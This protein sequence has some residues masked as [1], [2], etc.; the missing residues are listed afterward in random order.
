MKRVVARES[1]IVGTYDDETLLALLNGGTL[2]LTDQY[3]NAAQ[4]IWRPL[5]DFIGYSAPVRRLA[6]ALLRICAL[7]VAAGCGSLATWFYLNRSE[8]S[9]TQAPPEPAPEI[10]PPP[11]PSTPPPS[12]APQITIPPAEKLVEKAPKESKT[13]PSPAIELLNVEVFDEEVAVTVQNIGPAAANGF[14][15]KLKYFVLPGNQLVF[16]SN[17]RAIAQIEDAKEKRVKQV[18]VL[19]ETVGALERNL[20]LISTDVFEWTPSHIKALPTA[21]QWKSFG[22]AELGEAGEALEATAAAFAT[23][24]SSALPSARTTALSEHLLDLARRTEDLKPLLARAIERTMRTRGHLLA[25]QEIEAGR[26]KGLL[27]EQNDLHPLLAESMTQASRYTI[28]IEIVH[29]DGVIE[30]ELV[31]RITVK[32]EKNERHGVVVELVRPD[33]KTVAASDGR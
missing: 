22:D 25:E 28:R 20:K 15:L 27:R 12:P 7:L 21:A 9:L 8:E 5:T 29:V 32:R 23:G 3:W 4:S 18:A 11:A 26:L 30:P 1:K 6:P 14:D 16:D 31:R 2:K 17:Q 19:D 33:T 10:A 13:V 24:A